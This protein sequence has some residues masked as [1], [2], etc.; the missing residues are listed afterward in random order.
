MVETDQGFLHAHDVP[1]HAEMGQQAPE[2]LDRPHDTVA[3]RQ[4]PGG[5]QKSG[6]KLRAVMSGSESVGRD[7]LDWASAELGV[8]VN[9]GFGQTEANLVIG[10]CARIMPVKSGSLGKAVPGHIA[11]I[12]S[13]DGEIVKTGDVGNIAIKRPDPVFMKEYW[14]NP[15]ATAKK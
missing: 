10:N 8:Q 14:R 4:I 6:T 9:E 13:D 2:E 5:A 1:R 12:V 7:L 3:V 15:E 11:A